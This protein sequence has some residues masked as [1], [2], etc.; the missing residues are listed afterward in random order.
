[1]RVCGRNLSAAVL[2]NSTAFVWRASV[3]ALEFDQRQRGCDCD[4]DCDY[5]CDIKKQVLTPFSASP[6]GWPCLV[7]TFA[8]AIPPALGDW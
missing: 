2:H 4:C 7:D 1:M 6:R 5:D 8:P 3:H